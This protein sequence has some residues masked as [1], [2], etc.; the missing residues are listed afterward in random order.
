M[1]EIFRV[2]IVERI[3]N[4]VIRVFHCT[5]EHR[6]H[7][8]CMHINNPTPMSTAA[9]CYNNSNVQNASPA[10]LGR[11]ETITLTHN[12]NVHERRLFRSLGESGLAHVETL[13]FMDERLERARPTGRRWRV[14]ALGTGADVVRT[15]MP[16]GAYPASDQIVTRRTAKPGL[17]IDFSRSAS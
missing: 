4:F 13:V 2:S 1:R 7:S 15:R 17:R 11:G 8:V 9:C 14:T 3:L 10:P 6:E 16:T 12:N 5:I